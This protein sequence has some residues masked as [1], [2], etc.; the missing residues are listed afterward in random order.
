MT[1]E[2]ATEYAVQYRTYIGGKFERTIPYETKGKAQEQVE[3]FNKGKDKSLHARV[4][5]RQ[6]TKWVAA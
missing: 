1:E 2:M 6:V 3:K 4:A 5:T